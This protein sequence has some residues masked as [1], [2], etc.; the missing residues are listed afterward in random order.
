M[1]ALE[2]A[3][4]KNRT[5][6]KP[7]AAAGQINIKGRLQWGRACARARQTTR[8][9][10]CQRSQRGSPLTLQQPGCSGSQGPRLGP[11]LPQEVWG[12]VGT[13]LVT[14]H[15]LLSQDPARPSLA[16]L[17]T[18][19]RSVSCITDCFCFIF[20]MTP[21]CT[22]GEKRASCPQGPIQV[23]PPIAGNH[24]EL[25]GDPPPP[26]SWMEHGEAPA[27]LFRVQ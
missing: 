20:G 23:S 14:W 15:M 22:K 25:S 18:R 10:T 13:R 8:W 16:G 24:N 4:R 3:A 17:Q 21:A 19:L 11:G 9:F 6:A 2:E 5:C 26:R 12:S 7:A 1:P 27:S